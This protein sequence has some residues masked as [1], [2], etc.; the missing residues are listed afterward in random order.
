MLDLDTEHL[1]DENALFK[2]FGDRYIE[3][4]LR[5]VGTKFSTPADQEMIYEALCI[6]VAIYMKK[7]K[8]GD[9]DERIL[10]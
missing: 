9:I 1:S 7:V 2:A 3:D 6:M 4:A 8:D 10:H 5:V